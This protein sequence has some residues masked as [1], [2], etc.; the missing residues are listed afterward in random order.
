MIDRAA[1]FER[2]RGH[3]RILVAGAGG[4]FD[5]MCGLP[6]A[7]ALEAMGKTVHLA[8]LTF[9]YLGGSDAASFHPGVHEVRAETTGDPR[10]FPEKHLARWLRAQGRA[11]RVWTLEK[12]GLAPL[13]SAYA[14]LV[15]RLQIDAVVLVDGGTD[16]LMHGPE[17]GLGT[18]AE[19]ITSLL[20]ASALSI[21]T[22]L[23]ACVGFGVDTHHGVC[24]AD[25]LENVAS[26]AKAGA[27][28]GAFS[29]LAEADEVKLYLDAVDFVQAA[30]PG[31]ESIVSASI[32]DAIR[33]AS[34][35]HHAIARTRESGTSLFINPLM[36][37]VWGFDL[38]AVAARCAYR[39]AL[40]RTQTIFEVH[41]AIE[42]YRHSIAP[43]A[44]RVLPF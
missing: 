35:D 14:H 23:L 32:A 44:A 37:L 20:A 7:F 15:E 26:L 27:Y 11:D 30:T 28:L 33:G 42:R 34:G 3:E 41:L 31:R 36:S 38:D 29:L 21:P 18:P 6:I 5:V 4:G 24:H 43:R 2:L 13:T 9:S 17:A 22:K 1:M 12:V 40:A 19:D 39:D 25:F 16:I 8:N 10:Y